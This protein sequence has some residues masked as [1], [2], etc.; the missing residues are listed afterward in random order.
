MESS[1]LLLDGQDESDQTE[2]AASTPL[3][4]ANVAP[5]HHEEES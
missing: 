4:Y 3:P 5:V 2:Y 1:A